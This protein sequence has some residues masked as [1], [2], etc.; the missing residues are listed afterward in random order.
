ML[1][2]RLP[3]G[4][5]SSRRCQ[6]SEVVRRNLFTKIKLIGHMMCLKILGG[7]LNVPG[8]ECGVKLLMSKQKTKKG[9][10]TY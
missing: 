3:T 9:E 5:L 1:T 4:H 2:L 7:D 10:N 8:E 6:C